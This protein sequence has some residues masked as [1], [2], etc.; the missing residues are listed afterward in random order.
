MMDGRCMEGIWFEGNSA[1]EVRKIGNSVW[2]AV[3]REGLI[4]FVRPRI[5]G[6][7]ALRLRSAAA[8]AARR[9][10]RP[11]TNPFEQQ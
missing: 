2:G 1:M 4:A 6:T 8:C 9:K 10:Q 5:A 3:V 11:G 7:Y